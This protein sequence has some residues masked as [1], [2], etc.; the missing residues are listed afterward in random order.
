MLF[1]QNEY[2]HRHHH[3]SSIIISSVRLYGQR[4]T[5][6]LL[7]L[8]LLLLLYTSLL[9]VVLSC[10][11]PSVQASSS[12]SPLHR[13]IGCSYEKIMNLP[14]HPSNNTLITQR[15]NIT[16]HFEDFTDLP[17]GFGCD[18]IQFPTEISS[19]PFSTSNMEQGLHDI[20]S[21]V[22]ASSNTMDLCSMFPENTSCVETFCGVNSTK[23]NAQDSYQLANFCQY[24][25]KAKDFVQF[26]KIVAG[27][28][29]YDN[30]SWTACPAFKKFPSAFLCRNVQIGLPIYFMDRYFIRLRTPFMCYCYK[31][32]QYS[33][34][35]EESL[36]FTLK[37]DSAKLGILLTL[38]VPL[39]IAIMSLIVFPEC[40]SFRYQ[41]PT[42]IS[43]KS[44]I[45]MT[46]SAVCI[47]VASG[48]SYLPSFNDSN[49]LM[50]LLEN[51]TLSLNVFFTYYTIIPVM[52][53]FDR[54]YMY[55][56]TGE[57]KNWTLFKGLSY[58]SVIV[59]TLCMIYIVASFIYQISAHTMELNPPMR[60][61]FGVGY[62]AY[63]LPWFCN[64]ALFLL[65]SY[66]LGCVLKEKTNISFF[67]TKYFYQ[68]ML[69][70][71]LTLLAL[72]S[73]LM[74]FLYTQF[75]VTSIHFIVSYYTEFAAHC[76]NISSLLAVVMILF[77]KD[78]F[79]ECYPCLKRISFR[80]KRRDEEEASSSLIA[81]TSGNS[82][83]QPSE[84][85]AGM[86]DLTTP[87]NSSATYYKSLHSEE[88]TNVSM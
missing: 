37:F 27:L 30:S 29:N 21:P 61:V 15:I 68:F 83:V 44:I 42:S 9:L 40:L 36:L 31:F 73:C 49:N 11:F 18:E 55:L 14:T 35:C 88:S 48:L 20:Y 63:A 78:K 65:V 52:L 12:S 87:Y 2:C 47:V 17:F 75:G 32:D 71:A 23:W 60:I 67:K 53:M 84:G 4:T 69:L 25:K 64:L 62:V 85:S 74:S 34:T 28:E 39:F 46:A 76:F 70:S 6:S 8:H 45:L 79:W 66:K 33:T 57:K 13:F 43:I 81:N 24:C 50:Y 56:K 38:S 16:D 5:T 3:H 19:Y 82:K 51:L 26:H 80:T 1:F 86:S 41:K 7:L 72:I 58:V 10:P 54:V 77:D 59:N 22:Q